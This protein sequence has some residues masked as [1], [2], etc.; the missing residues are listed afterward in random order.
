MSKIRAMAMAVLVAGMAS[1][2]VVAQQKTEV[3]A[4][5]KA[6]AGTNEGRPVIPPNKYEDF[7][8]MIKPG[9]GA[10]GETAGLEDI[11]WRLELWEARKEALEK[12]MP[13]LFYET[14][15]GHALAF[16]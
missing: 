10:V 5:T 3:Q 11:P 15:C 1:P 4:K 8:A 6:A 13:L 7:R 9:Y 14:S 12:G 16:S 2:A